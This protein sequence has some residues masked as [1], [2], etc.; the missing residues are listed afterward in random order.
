MA[1]SDAEISELYARYAGVLHHRCNR[2]L[3][4][5]AE[6]WDAVH[7]TFARVIRNS[8]SF[9]QQSSPYTW[10]MRISTNH[11]LNQLRNRKS[12]AQKLKDHGCELR[13]AL[14]ASESWED[15]ARVLA[16]LEHTDEETRRCV[17][18]TFFDDCTRAETAQLVGLSVPTVRKRISNFL[19]RAR[20]ALHT[21]AVAGLVVGVPMAWKVWS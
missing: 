12:R 17:V 10:M 8:S 7:E 21:A 19:D 11:C 3:R 14:G 16:L 5:E 4:D 2:I 13:P 20:K 9:R 6:A 1:F 15:H 18:H